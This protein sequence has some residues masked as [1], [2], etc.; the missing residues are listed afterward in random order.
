VKGEVGE[1]GRVVGEYDGRDVGG[2][3]LAKMMV[4]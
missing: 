4:N 3:K 2:E 1:L